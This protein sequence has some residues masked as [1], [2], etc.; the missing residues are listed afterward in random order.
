VIAGPAVVD[1][2]IYWGSGYSRWL[3]TSNNKLYAF[4]LGS[5][6]TRNR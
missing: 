1:G 5:L 3:Q 2:V 4:T 6:P